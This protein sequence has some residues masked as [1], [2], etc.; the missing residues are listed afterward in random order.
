M[1]LPIRVT[2]S[3]GVAET[4]EIHGGPRTP[5]DERIVPLVVEHWSN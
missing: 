2:I 4:A 1:N 3:S 5:V